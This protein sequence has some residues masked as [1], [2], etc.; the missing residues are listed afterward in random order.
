MEGWG[1]KLR[2]AEWG[3]ETISLA[4]LVGEAASLRVIWPF[5]CLSG[6]YKEKKM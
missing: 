2:Q 1:T 5:P 6:D 3:S 4:F